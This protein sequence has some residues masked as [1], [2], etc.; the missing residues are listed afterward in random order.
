MYFIAV[1]GS[2]KSTHSPKKKKRIAL[3]ISGISSYV[4]PKESSKESIIFSKFCIVDL[5]GTLPSSYDI[6]KHRAPI[7]LIPFMERIQKEKAKL[8]IHFSA[9]Q[10]TRQGHRINLI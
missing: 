10:H 5:D 2:D 3:K 7:E 6:Y 1:F 4:R 9:Q 8:H